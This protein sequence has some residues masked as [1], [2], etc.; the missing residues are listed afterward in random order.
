MDAET[1]F[2]KVL[3]YHNGS[4]HH[5]RRFAPGPG[6]LDWA[7]EPDPFRRYEGAPQIPL[8]F[9]EEDPDVNHFGLYL[10]QG[11]SRPL[12]LPAVASLLELSLGLS[13]WKSYKGNSWSL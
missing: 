5:P 10:R 1:G 9:L 4:K 7:N 13:A 8:P 3:A 12:T 2:N 11:K 6:F